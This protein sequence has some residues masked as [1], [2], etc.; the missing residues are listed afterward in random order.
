MRNELGIVSLALAAEI[1]VSGQA[2][3]K[4]LLRP[5]DADE[6]Q[7]PLLFQ[8]FGMFAAALV[9]QK[10]LFDGRQI[11]DRE[12]QAL[13]GVQRHQ[14]H[15]VGIGLPGVRIVDQAR[16]FQERLQLARAALP[17]VEIA[18]HGEQL[19][20][21]GQPLLVLLVFR[22]AQLLLIARLAQDQAQNLLDRAV[23]GRRKAIDQR[24]ELASRAAG[25][26]ADRRDAG[27]P[28]RET[29]GPPPSSGRPCCTA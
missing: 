22:L 5:G 3:L 10:S 7:P 28:G 17:L 9:R 18:G 21:V 4:L 23:D 29:A 16:L 26:A 8:L 20:D 15:P 2:D 25:A 6:H 1:A 24:H 27:S 13:R 14:R 12:L 19:L 11:H